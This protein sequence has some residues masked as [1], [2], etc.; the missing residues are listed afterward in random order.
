MREERQRE[1]ERLKGRETECKKKKKAV[2][3]MKNEER[4]IVRER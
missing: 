2:E 4:V 3:E 1:R